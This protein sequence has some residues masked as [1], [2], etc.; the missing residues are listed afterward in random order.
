MKLATRIIEKPWGRDDVPAGF[1]GGDGRQIGEIWFEGPAGAPAPLM[2]KYLFTSERLSIQV[3]PDDGAAAALGH[4]SGKDECWLVLDAAPDAEIGIGLTR[5]ATPDEVRTA[6]EAG[7]IER[8]I[9]WRPVKA[10]D[11]LYNPAGT[12][13]AIGPGLSLVEI[14]QN[15]ECTYRLY[16]YGRPRDLHLDIALAIATLA[17]HHD[18]RDRRVPAEGTVALVAGPLFH[19]LRAQGPLEPGDLPGNVALT[20]VP[21]R[22]DCRAGGEAMTPG[23]CAWVS[24]AAE[25]DLS[26]GAQALICWAADR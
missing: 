7:T 22:G 10:G 14:Q 6:A 2:V 17:P 16:D 4:S 1:G 19:V 15:S 21:L 26:H 3:H 12:I 11:F 8:L 20:L 9:D 13:H 25:I 18:A 24:N 23:E 5:P